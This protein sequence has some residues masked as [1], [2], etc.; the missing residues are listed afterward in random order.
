VNENPLLRREALGRV[1]L[2]ASLPAAELDRLAGT[3]AARTIPQGELLFLEGQTDD[4]LYILLEGQVEIVKALGSAGERLLGVRGPGPLLGEMSLF[5]P[6]HR[7]TAS[8]RARSP[9]EV[10]EMT[11]AE[12]DGLVHRHPELIYGMLGTLTRR[13]DEAE[14][15][16]IRELLEKNQQLTRAYDELKAAQAQLVEKERL[17]AELAIARS[18]QRSTLPH[19]KPRLAGFDFGMLIE[20]VAT[21]GGDLFDFVRLKGGRLGIAIGDVSGHGVPA[22][23]FM[24]LTYSLLRAEASRA[25]SPLKALRQV[26]RHLLDM[27]ETGMFV[28]MLYGVLQA[29]TR[30]FTYARAG[31]TPPLVLDRQ[32]TPLRPPVDV[33]QPL[34]ILPSVELDE[35]TV[36]VPPGGLLLLFTDG[37]TEAMDAQ[38]QQFGEERLLAALGARGH[39]SAQDACQ[40]AYDAVRAF[41]GDVLPHDDVLL[42]AAQVQ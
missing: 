42:V 25:H 15:L 6:E 37:V 12:L 35:Q 40:A 30:Q 4:R 33:G 20:P 9:L 8:V 36:T 10:L 7:H 27:N 3:L 23:F 41:C 21:V 29:D 11:R 18:L 2:F 17:D 39:G 13:L 28:T 34:G 16:T 31:H 19:S 14:N 22:A 5:S 1:P 32:G 24:A 38:G 26:N